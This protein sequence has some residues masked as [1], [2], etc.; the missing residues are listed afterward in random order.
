MKH[1]RGCCH[2][3]RRKSEGVER[4]IASY[5]ASVLADERSLSK[6]AESEVTFKW[7]KMLP[8]YKNCEKAS[9]KY[10]AYV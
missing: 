8:F 9:E 1:I 6:A 3:E 10:A 2:R 7:N 4:Q 5:P